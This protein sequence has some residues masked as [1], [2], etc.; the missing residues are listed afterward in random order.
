MDSRDIYNTG[1]LPTCNTVTDLLEALTNGERAGQDEP[2]MTS[3]CE[4]RWYSGVQLCEILGRFSNVVIIG[5]SLM[6]HLASAMHVFLRE[7]LIEGAFTSWTAKAEEQRYLE[8]KMEAERTGKEPPEPGTWDCRCD[9]AF[10]NG[11]CLFLEAWSSKAVYDNDA[12][13]MKCDRK[14]S[15][16]IEF[17][18][19]N[20]YPMGDHALD[21]LFE[22]LRNHSQTSTEYGATASAPKPHAVIFGNGL[23]YDLD[24]E[25]FKKWTQDLENAIAAGAR[26]L[27]PG[28]NKPRVP[29]LAVTPSAGG[30]LKP[31][32]YVDKQNNVKI[33]AFE[34]EAARWLH[35]RREGLYHMGT[36]NATILNSSPDGT[37]S[38][39]KAD[40][41]KAM[42]VFNWLDLVSQHPSG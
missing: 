17:G 25:T 41:L 32:K 3:G 38:G 9:R 30:P 15:S 5:D 7:D 27:F 20:E 34:D 6:R 11:G 29:M 2:F 35:G 19:S 13:S 10:S 36:Y 28:T 16:G 31:H 4:M 21:A 12:S 1:R 18:I 14:F 40:L 42:M 22:G 8:Q 26:D 33:K 39:I 24:I 37:H 23:W